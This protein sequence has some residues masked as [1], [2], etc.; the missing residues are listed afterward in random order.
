MARRWW[1]TLVL[2]LLVGAL[3]AVA[4]L[5]PGSDDSDGRVAQ[6]RGEQ[7]NEIRIQRRNEETLAF[8]RGETGW[9]MTEPSELPASTFH[10]EQVLA[11]LQSRSLSSYHP[12]ELQRD[13]LG[14]DPP[15]V[16]LSLEGREL[17]LGGSHPVGNRRYLQHAGRVHL[18]QEGVMPLLEGPWWNFIDRH[19]VFP[20]RTL[21]RVETPDFT[22]Q[23]EDDLWRLVEGELPE[24]VS[25]DEV[26]GAWQAA[27]ALVVRSV[28]RE[29]VEHAPVRLHWEDGGGRL[30][31]PE[32][33]SGEARLTDPE[34]GLAYAL[35]QRLRGYLLSGRLPDTE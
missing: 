23:R 7:V 35:D 14:L 20:G 25:A 30:L 31:R 24:E 21:H 19:L 18:V 28:R 34:R 32:D 8:R 11:L 22:L 2:F 12:D 5:E 6:L 17:L 4:W 27:S 33:E 3:A 15:R 29:A 1:L 13:Q 10:L 16:R 9:S 26:G